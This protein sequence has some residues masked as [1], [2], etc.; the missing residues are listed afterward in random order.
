M[1]FFFTGVVAPNDGIVGAPPAEVIPVVPPL[2]GLRGGAPG[3]DDALVPFDDGG[4]RGDWVYLGDCDAAALDPN[5]LPGEDLLPGEAG[6]VPPFFFFEN[7]PR[8][9]FGMFLFGDTAVSV[10][11]NPS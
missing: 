7:I 4:L 5:I 3:E 6:R 9:T 11:S 2:P 8:L 1:F 10:T